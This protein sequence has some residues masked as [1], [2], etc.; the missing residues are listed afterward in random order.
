VLAFR[1]LLLRYD[2]DLTAVCALRRELADRPGDF[3]DRPAQIDIEDTVLFG[4]DRVKELQRNT[5][6][7]DPTENGLRPG[8]A[9]EPEK[10][11][12]RATS[13]DSQ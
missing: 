13:N 6:G 2:V 9:R 11:A 7:P 3:L 12:S 5:A 10:N 8:V 4:D 1:Q